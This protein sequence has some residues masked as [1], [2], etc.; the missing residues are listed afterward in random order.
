MEGFISSNPGLQSRFNRY[1]DFP[2]YSNEELI[3]IFKFV[4][5][6]NDCIVT[7]DALLQVRKYIEKAKGNND[8]CLGNARFIRNLFER[9]ITQQANRLVSEVK[10]TN[11]MLSQIEASD[12][13]N[14]IA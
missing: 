11:E 8:L 4:V 1:I 12:V 5:K 2:D 7:E 13:E 3:E 6:K 9:V 14:A 10:I